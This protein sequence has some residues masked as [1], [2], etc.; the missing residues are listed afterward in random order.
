MGHRP[1]RG[2]RGR[3]RGRALPERGRDRGAGRRRGRGCSSSSRKAP[4]PPRRLPFGENVVAVA[5]RKTRCSPATARGQLLFGSHERGA[6]GDDPRVVAPGRGLAARRDL[7]AT[8]GRFWIRAGTAL[9][10][11]TLP[12]AP[13]AVRDRGVLAIAASGG[14]LV[15]VT[16]GP[17]GA[18]IERFRGDDEG[19]MEAP[20]RGAASTLV[21]ERREAGSI[22]FAAAA[23]GR[24][25][26]LGDDD[27][28]LVSRDGGATF[29]PVEPGRAAALAFAGEDASAALLVLTVPA[30]S[31]APPA[32]L[33]EVG[34]AGEAAR[35]GE[36]LPGVGELPAALAWD[37]SRDVIWVASGAGLAALGTPRRH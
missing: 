6:R 31:G 33:V 15:A 3:G 19:A 34:A 12:G 17:A 25:L 10:C 22:L 11:A 14:T 23:G 30:P 18:R 29:A 28:V 7:C 2:G 4:A 32:F 36:S 13:A 9:S 27:R 1:R 35:I 37:A 24:C 5:L 21:A 20:L 8:P 16:L 26:A